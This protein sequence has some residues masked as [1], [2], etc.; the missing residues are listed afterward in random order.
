MLPPI[1]NANDQWGR[2]NEAYRKV[3]TER[4]ARWSG[5]IRNWQPEGA[6]MLDPEREK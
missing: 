6:V 4:P 3:K 2:N 1:K 5:K